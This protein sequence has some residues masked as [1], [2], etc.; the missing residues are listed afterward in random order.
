M[1][2]ADDAFR[3]AEYA[4][5]LLDG[6]SR[7]AFETRLGD[8]VALR[9]EVAFWEDRLATTLVAAGE[10]APPAHVLERV[11]TSLFGRPEA[12]APAAAAFPWKRFVLGLVAVKLVLLTAW[13]VASTARGPADPAPGRGAEEMILR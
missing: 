12:R 9:R 6:P 8:E 5:G 7:Q 4:L 3:S 1:T 13:Y 2:S 10:A 11:E